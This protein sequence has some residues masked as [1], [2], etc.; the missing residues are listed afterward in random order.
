MTFGTFDIHRAI[1]FPQNFYEPSKILNVLTL[2]QLFVAVINRSCFSPK[3]SRLISAQFPPHSE[4]L[5]VRFALLS[6]VSIHPSHSHSSLK[7]PNNE[8]SISSSIPMFCHDFTRV[9]Q[10]IHSSI[11]SPIHPFECRRR[12]VGQ[13]S[14]I[15]LLRK[16]ERSN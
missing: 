12:E 3:Q 6:V 14:N 13:H 11:H 10:S 7:Q 2:L 8:P 16:P 15:Y 9:H 4:T 1:Q 5:C